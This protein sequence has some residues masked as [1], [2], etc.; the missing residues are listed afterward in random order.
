MKTKNS[1]GRQPASCRKL[2][3]LGLLF[4]LAPVR[5]DP[6]R[7][8][9]TEQPDRPHR[10]S[11]RP[12]GRRLVPRR[13]APPHDGSAVPA[14]FSES[15]PDFPG[16]SVTAT[17]R[18]RRREYFLR[19]QSLL[20]RNGFRRAIYF[21][22]EPKADCRDDDLVGSAGP[23]TAVIEFGSDRQDDG[24]PEAVGDGAAPADRTPV[25][26]LRRIGLG[27]SGGV[28]ENLTVRWL[29]LRIPLLNPDTAFPERDVARAPAPTPAPSQGGGDGAARN[30]SPNREHN[31][32]QADASSPAQHRH[33]SCTPA[34]A[35][36][37]LDASAASRL[38]AILWNFGGES[39][40][41]FFGMLRLVAP[42]IVSRRFLVGLGDAVAD[43][44]R[45][46]YF[47]KTYTRA[48]RV[49]IR[50]YEAPALARAIYRAGCQLGVLMVLSHTVRA[51]VV[52]F[53]TGGE[54]FGV[55]VLSFPG[56]FIW[57]NATIWGGVAVQS[58][59]TSWFKPLRIQISE[60]TYRR[61]RFLS[62]PALATR[63][64]HIFQWLANPAEWLNVRAMLRTGR[65]RP[66]SK[67]FVPS[68]LLFPATWVPVRICQMVAVARILSKD[69]GH[70]SPRH[71]NESAL[72]FRVATEFLVQVAAGDEWFRIFFV[73][74][75][76]G[77][78]L[79]VAIAYLVSLLAVAAT[80]SMMDGAAT[81]FMV[82][83]ILAVMVSA[84]MNL[85]IYRARMEAD[86]D[87]IA[88]LRF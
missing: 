7:L 60:D 68:P 79:V 49:L 47:R 53:F 74:K 71:T 37:V 24:C 4:L 85:A 20:L 23:G 54:L 61:N 81:L 22:S 21:L 51:V 16:G 78:G 13:S 62:I 40:A 15:P 26:A 50:Y 35:A 3:R 30:T 28:R 76:V 66:N 27:K 44:A 6:A 39:A 36:L 12:G 33:P 64:W 9:S 63:P 72:M 57:I 86:R 19:R 52:L 56:A 14:S 67:D 82:P 31:V 34:Q 65:G 11:D 17:A 88:S 2:G 43:Y 10:P 80:S 25:A 58:F 70:Y 59:L 32:G 84:G 45:G 8:R 77:L 38:L 83:S 29:R 48:E 73:E 87:Y 46:R 41:A 75:R 69:P 1:A 18:S 55:S 42:L 5:G